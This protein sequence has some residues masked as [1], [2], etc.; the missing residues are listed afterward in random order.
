[1]HQKG[2]KNIVRGVRNETDSEYEKDLA[3]KMKSFDQEFETE[4]IMC[5]ENHENISSTIVREHIRNG[6]ELDDLLPKEIVGEVRKLF[7]E[8]ALKK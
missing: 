6:T 5:K 2:I 3:Q 8:N 1:M 7:S 4:I